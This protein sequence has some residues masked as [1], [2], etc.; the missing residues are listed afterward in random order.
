MLPTTYRK[1]EYIENATL[2][3]YIDTGLFASLD[4]MVVV[5]GYAIE[6][7]TALFGSR[8]EP[9]SV[10]CFTL[11]FLGAGSMAYRFTIHTVQITAPTSFEKG[12]RHIF[13]FGNA[14]FKIDDSVIGKANAR[15]LESYYPIYM[16]GAMNNLGEASAF[17]LTRIYSA[18]FYKG[19]E[20]AG[21][22]IPCMSAEGEVGF[23][24]D[25]DGSFHGNAG[26]G[27]LTGAAEPFFMI[28]IA[29]LPEKVS[30]KKGES[31][32][33][34]GMVVEAICESGYR[35]AVSDYEVRGYDSTKLGAQ[36]ITV[37][38]QGMTDSFAVIVEEEPEP[39]IVV[40]FITPDE[41][42]QYLRV[43]F[44]DDD[45]LI[46]M[47]IKSSEKLC[48]DIAR[49]EE[50]TEYEKLENAKIAVMYAVAF[51]YEHREDA[52][53]H[54]LNLTLRDLLFGDRKA[55]F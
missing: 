46:D 26:I 50:K 44:E 6:G 2:G 4:M 18:K 7:N 35:E 34:T 33:L 15:A 41:M 51:Q 30:Y 10:D 1:M 29:S 52:D 21:D 13:T 23:Y 9:R 39:P 42:K 45:A 14:E 12:V 54:K 38:Y 49:V 48:M 25:V 24:N 17:G 47:L 40:P 11:Q 36:V 3:S 5:D 53:H 37:A 16:L 27:E 22:F 31:I 20:L 43:D 19:E 28:E 55:G 32:N 8:T